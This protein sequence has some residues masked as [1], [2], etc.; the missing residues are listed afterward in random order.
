M[1]H[2]NQDKS[3]RAAIFYKSLFAAVCAGGLV[4]AEVGDRAK[5]RAL[6]TT[7]EEMLSLCQ[8]KFDGVPDAWPTCVEDSKGSFERAAM[9]HGALKIGSGLGLALLLWLSLY[10]F[11]RRQFEGDTPDGPQ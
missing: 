6:G 11:K 7:P 8:K 10:E 5:D 3:R 4:A 2:H 9:A 1:T